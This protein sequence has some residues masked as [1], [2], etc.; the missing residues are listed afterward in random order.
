MSFLFYTLE[1]LIWDIDCKRIPLNRNESPTKITKT[2]T[3]I[4]NDDCLY[5]TMDGAFI[6][7]VYTIDI[8]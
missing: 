2:N 3:N 8:V 5:W 7:H 6:F 1:Y 4:Q